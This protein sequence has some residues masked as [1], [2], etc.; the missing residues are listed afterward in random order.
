MSRLF[1]KLW[2]SYIHSRD[3]FLNLMYPGGF[4][5][6]M[7]DKLTEMG[8][9][10]GPGETFNKWS[11]STG[12]WI[13]SRPFAGEAFGGRLEFANEE[14]CYYGSDK[15]AFAS[16]LMHIAANVEIRSFV[17]HTV[18]DNILYI[19]STYNFYNHNLPI[20]VGYYAFAYPGLK[21]CR[22]YAIG[23]AEFSGLVVDVRTALRNKLNVVQGDAEYK[24][25]YNINNYNMFKRDGPAWTARAKYQEARNKIIADRPPELRDL[26]ISTLKPLF[27]DD[28]SLIKQMDR[29]KRDFRSAAR[30]YDKAKK[31]CMNI[32]DD[33]PPTFHGSSC[34]CVDNASHL[35]SNA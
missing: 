9:I 18:V 16:L 6:T 7:I 32:E 35:L 3:Q 23:P 19:F 8:Y 30:G 26:P 31:V 1:D 14:F 22:S 33:S 10:M 29:A 25:K 34:F 5:N 12:S 17:I 13:S 4:T 27:C 11:F 2:I 15:N 20:M 28:S 21:Q 24:I